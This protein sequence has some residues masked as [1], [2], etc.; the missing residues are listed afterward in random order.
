MKMMVDWSLQ[1]VPA[2]TTLNGL[3]ATGWTRTTSESLTTGTWTIGLREST[4]VGEKFLI[5]V[6]TFTLMPVITLRFSIAHPTIVSE[7]TTRVRRCPGS[8]ADQ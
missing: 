3:A 1:D 6:I 8:G 7:S 5:E 2:R 4:R